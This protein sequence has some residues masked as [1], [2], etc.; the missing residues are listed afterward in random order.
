MNDR[1]MVMI[2]KRQIDK[3]QIKKGNLLFMKE[4]QL[5]NVDRVI[6][7]ENKS[8]FVKHGNKN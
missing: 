4:N 3:R 2:D 5:I 1:Q 7:L 8:Q 6:E